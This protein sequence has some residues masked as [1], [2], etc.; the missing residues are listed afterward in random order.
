MK[1]RRPKDPATFEK[2]VADYMSTW[3]VIAGC[4]VIVTIILVITAIWYFI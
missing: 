4:G 2:D 3:N 1:I